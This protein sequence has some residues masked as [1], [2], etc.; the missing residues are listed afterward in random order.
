MLT[1]CVGYSTYSHMCIEMVPRLST[2][3][4]G[5]CVIQYGAM[6]ASDVRLFSAWHATASLN[7]FAATAVCSHS[8]L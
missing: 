3:I 1:A 7:K 6:Q 8:Q 5:R 2:A 4:A